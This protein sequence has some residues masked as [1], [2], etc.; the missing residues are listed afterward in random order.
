MYNILGDFLEICIFF[1]F[2]PFFPNSCGIAPVLYFS[3]AYEAY[4]HGLNILKYYLI[5]ISY[6]PTSCAGSDL[7]LRRRK[8]LIHL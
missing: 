2:K 8:K 6:L 3:A 4:I 5:Y 7:P 1:R